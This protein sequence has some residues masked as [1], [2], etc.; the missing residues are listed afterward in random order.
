[1]TTHSSPLAGLLCNVYETST[2][3][4]EHKQ[5]AATAVES[6]FYNRAQPAPSRIGDVLSFVHRVALNNFHHLQIAFTAVNG[7]LTIYSAKDFVLALSHPLAKAS[8]ETYFGP[9]LPAAAL[10]LIIILANRWILSK[11]MDSG[12]SK[13]QL[14]SGAVQLTGI[15]QSLALAAITENKIALLFRASMN[16]YSLYKNN[17]FS[18][19]TFSG[20][21]VDHNPFYDPLRPNI[22]R[23]DVNY[24]ALLFSKELKG[25]KCSICTDENPPADQVFCTEGH[26]FHQE[27]LNQN[28]NHD[29]ARLFQADQYLRTQINHM[30]NGRQTGTSYSYKVSIQEDKLPSCPNCRERPP[31]NHFNV[32]VH[33]EKGTFKASV[34]I[35]ETN[36]KCHQRTFE[37][38][39]AIYNAFKAVLALLQQI[40]EFTGGITMLRRLMIITDTT[41]AVLANYYLSKNLKR[42]GYRWYLGV[43]PALLSAIPLLF[44]LEHLFGPKEDLSKFNLT[45]VKAQWDRPFVEGVHLYIEAYRLLTTFGLTYFSKAHG[46]FN[47]TSLVSQGIAIV[48]AMNVHWLRVDQVNMG[49]LQAEFSTYTPISTLSKTT[50]VIR[51]AIAYITNLQQRIANDG[52]AEIISHYTNGVLTHKTMAITY[53]LEKIRD[54]REYLIN[55]YIWTW[56]G[57]TG[58]ALY[59]SF[60][61]KERFSLAVH[62]L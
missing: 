37:K 25:D 5:T 48:G 19:L 29:Q 24:S 13:V 46:T 52:T 27:C 42:S 36:P 10:A 35:N 60:G 26:T 47:I 49:W 23:I 39:Y 33:D 62:L 32:T 16:A 14:L 7:L 40:P 43:A 20:T 11:T 18:W 1:M 21:H 34:N 44:G 50:E 56:D 38:V 9:T 4:E 17:K 6:L 54:F 55:P 41:L 53:T 28:F 45:G 59:G 15:L 57:L 31:Q 51:N 30:T 12:K 61:F 3:L 58:D 8:C 22:N 2:I